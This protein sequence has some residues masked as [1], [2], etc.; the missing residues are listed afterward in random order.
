MLLDPHGVSLCFPIKKKICPLF[1]VHSIRCP[2]LQ[3]EPRTY[4]SISRQNVDF[5]ILSTMIFRLETPCY[6]RWKFR[7]VHI[8]PKQHALQY[9]LWL[10]LVTPTSALT[11]S[12]IRTAK[13]FHC[14]GQCVAGGHSHWLEVGLC[15]G[16]NLNSLDKLLG[17]KGDKLFITNVK[18]LLRTFI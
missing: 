12:I 18:H 14:A 4:L 15:E 3:S 2:S 5:G 6:S 16:Q 1:A 9:V 13:A 8:I 7:Y 17:C 10:H 11:R